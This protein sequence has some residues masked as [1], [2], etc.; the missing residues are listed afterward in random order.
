MTDEEIELC[1]K[2]SNQTVREMADLVSA[3][4]DEDKVFYNASNGML[5]VCP[6]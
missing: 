1:Q 5:E 2:S 4:M 3:A 6:F